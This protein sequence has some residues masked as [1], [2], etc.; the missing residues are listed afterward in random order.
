M[1]LSAPV[2]LEEVIDY[3]DFKQEASVESMEDES[4]LEDEP[5]EQDLQDLMSG[6]ITVNESRII[7]ISRGKIKRKKKKTTKTTV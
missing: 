2:G 4:T 5:D 3:A 1:M 6:N 7:T